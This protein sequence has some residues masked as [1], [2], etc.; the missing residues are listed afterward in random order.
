MSTRH[1]TF[2]KEEHPLTEEFWYRLDGSP[3]CKTRIKEQTRVRQQGAKYKEYQKKYKEENSEYIKELNRK[4]REENHEYH[5]ARARSWYHDNKDRVRTRRRVYL[6][7]RERN[8]LCFKLARRLRS[9]LYHVLTGKTKHASHVRDLGC[10]L[11][12][13]KT[14]LEGNFREGMSW[15][16]Y[17]TVWEIDHIKPLSRYDLS[18]PNV[19]A[20][21]VHYTNLNPLF[22]E[23]N[24]KKGNKSEL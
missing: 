24:R 18:D 2:C 15:D 1:C 22:V 20:E 4:W 14:Y 12:E 23:E 3:R 8:D 9:R 21:L 10:S 19:Q 13:L 11:E 5:C 6:K 7:E 17:G 16:N